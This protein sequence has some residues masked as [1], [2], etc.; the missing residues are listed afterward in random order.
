M[1]SLENDLDEEGHTTLP[2]DA[3]TAAEN[4]SYRVK[5]GQDGV[6]DVNEVD[7]HV[8]EE[9]VENVNNAGRKEEIIAEDVGDVVVEDLSRNK[10]VIIDL[11][12]QD[13]DVD[14][15]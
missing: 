5:Q 14:S 3:T 15:R 10:D 1:F 12:I 8:D 9:D 11:P 7:D 13:M 4:S 6:D 2:G